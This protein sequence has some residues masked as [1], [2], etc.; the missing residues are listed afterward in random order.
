MYLYGIFCLL[1]TLII[2]FRRKIL[3]KYL[4][5]VLSVVTFLFTGSLPAKAVINQLNQLRDY[6]EYSCL[7]DENGRVLGHD[8]NKTK[9]DPNG[10]TYDDLL[11]A[12][13]DGYYYFNFQQYT[14]CNSPYTKFEKT[15]QVYKGL[16]IV[17]YKNFYDSKHC[18]VVIPSKRY[19]S[20]N[21]HCDLAVLKAKRNILDK[22]PS[23]TLV[24]NNST[25]SIEVTNITDSTIYSDSRLHTTLKVTNGTP[26]IKNGWLIIKDGDNGIDQ[27][28]K[29]EKFNTTEYVDV[30]AGFV[31]YKRVTIEALVEYENGTKLTIPFSN[32]ITYSQ[33]PSD[34][35]EGSAELPS[36]SNPGFWVGATLQVGDAIS[37][38]VYRCVGKEQSILGYD[39]SENNR[40]LSCVGV[41]APLPV[42]RILNI[43]G[44]KYTVVRSIVKKGDTV[45]ELAPVRKA[46]PYVDGVIHT[47][48]SG[49]KL[50]RSWF[51]DFKLTQGDD[52]HGYTHIIKNHAHNVHGGRRK[53]GKYFFETDIKNLIEEALT[54]KIEKATIINDVTTSGEVVYIAEVNM[55]RVIGFQPVNLNTNNFKE[56]SK[57]RILLLED[58]TIKTAYPIK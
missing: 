28:H 16:Q 15:N 13:I 52:F 57:L 27:I 43:T 36:L 23:G 18:L 11:N 29:F 31:H 51:A 53:G 47:T 49:Q 33:Y 5:T 6:T 41:I 10:Y 24:L 56:L 3:Y 1:F 32:S 14:D 48:Y 34:Y 22:V 9:Y 40:L 2:S 42:G 37:D 26:A 38:D 54:T 50:T 44:K 19:S 20:S 7:F 39:I 4:F 30:T 46:L 21:Y 12:Y 55:G 8:P 35:I 25:A 17:V 45:V 58:G